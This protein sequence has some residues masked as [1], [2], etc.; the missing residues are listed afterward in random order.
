[1]K[2]R[3]LIA[4]IALCGLLFSCGAKQGPSSESN[5]GTDSHENEQAELDRAIDDAV[6]LINSINLDN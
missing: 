5:T 1:M 2:K 4:L 3:S 6:A